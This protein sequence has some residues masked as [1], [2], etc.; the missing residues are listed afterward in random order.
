MFTT[1]KSSIRRASDASLLYPPPQGR[2]GYLPGRAVYLGSWERGKS[3]LARDRLV[4]KAADPVWLS[5]YSCSQ[6]VTLEGRP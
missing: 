3:T 5:D 6:V 1:Q 4:F 2:S